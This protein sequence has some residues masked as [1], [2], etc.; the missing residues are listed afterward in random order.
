MGTNFSIGVVME[1][2]IGFMTV[3]LAFLIGLVTG[4]VVMSNTSD[5]PSLRASEFCSKCG[6]HLYECRCDQGVR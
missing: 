6:W 3:L 4:M 1:F 5:T 2:F